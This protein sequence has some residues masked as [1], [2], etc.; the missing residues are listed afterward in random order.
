MTTGEVTPHSFVVID[1]DGANERARDF[2]FAGETADGLMYG[3]YVPSMDE[4]GTGTTD[5]PQ[6]VSLA[7]EVEGSDGG[8]FQFT[9]HLLEIKD[10]SFGLT[11]PSDPDLFFDGTSFELYLSFAANVYRYTSSTMDG[12]FSGKAQ[13]SSNQGGV[14][15]GLALGDGSILSF[16]NQ[17]VTQAGTKIYVAQHS[18]SAT[19]VS[20]S[21]VALDFSGLAGSPQSAE[22]PGVIV[23]AP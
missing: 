17:G 1:A 11:G 13:L 15:T 4:T 14:P 12:T 6:Y 22:S 19:S 3:V 8:C 2:A 21:T 23:N 5:S 20:F 9:R 10:G 18:S 7:T 16:V